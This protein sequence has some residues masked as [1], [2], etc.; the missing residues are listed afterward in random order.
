[1][2]PTASILAALHDTVTVVRSELDGLEDW[3]RAP[4]HE[5]Q[6]RHDVIADEAAVAVLDKAGFAVLSE[7]SGLHH[8]ERRLLAV[9]DPV[10]GSTNAARG[11]PWWATSVCV[12]DHDGPLAAVVANQVSGTRYEASRGGGATCGGSPIRPSGCQRVENAIVGFSG[13]PATYFGWA[14]YRSLGAASLDMCAVAAGNLDAFVAP[15]R[16]PL[17]PWDYLGAVLVCEEAGA[18]VADLAGED[19]VTRS[20]AARRAPVAAASRPLLAGLLDARSRIG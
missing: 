13:Y 2:A 8:P 19:L 9:I 15:R 1:M 14:Q 6:Y 17:S 20:S 7:E 4:G 12:L 5:G 3:G 16:H 18:P 10:D 11:I